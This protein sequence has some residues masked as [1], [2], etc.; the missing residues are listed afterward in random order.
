VLEAGQAMMVALAYAGPNGNDGDSVP[1]SNRMERFASAGVAL[2][3]ILIGAAL[4]KREFAAPPQRDAQQPVYIDEWSSLE[5][6]GTR[7]GRADAR[8]KIIEFMDLECPACR[9]LNRSW[10]DV[11]V[12]HPDDVAVIFVHYP[13]SYHRF[14]RPAA[15]AVECSKTTG[16]TR[17]FVDALYDKQDSLGIKPWAGF[18]IDAGIADGKAVERCATANEPTPAIDAGIAAGK[19]VGVSGTPTIIFNGWK[20]PG[21]PADTLIERAI[22][23][24]LA[25]R[26]P[27]LSR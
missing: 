5:S 4:V 25:G 27:F 3:V 16:K 6:A 18:A 11:L 22:Q 14:A 7:L 19:R 15:R 8:V 10:R 23:D 2:G 1:E 26:S 21:V 20:L 12:K 9:F 24:V 17:E 13:L